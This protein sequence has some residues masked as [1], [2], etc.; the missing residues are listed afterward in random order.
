MASAGNSV[1][2]I[3]RTARVA[4]EIERRMALLSREAAARVVADAQA[5]A[6]VDTG[7]LRDSIRAV[8]GVVPTF[9]RVEATAPHAQFVEYGTR[10][11]SAQPYLIPAL[12]A[13]RRGF[14]SQMAGAVGRRFAG[15]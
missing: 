13:E 4:F 11:Q 10:F 7:Q 2:V 3:D 5:R 9:W 8:P 14:V 6:P 1:R 12:E 15:R